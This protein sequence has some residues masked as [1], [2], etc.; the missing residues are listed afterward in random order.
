MSKVIKFPDINNLPE[1]IKVDDDYIAR[2]KVYLKVFK[3]LLS[4]KETQTK[5]TS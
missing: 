1:Y 4:T 2:H 5:N 3:H